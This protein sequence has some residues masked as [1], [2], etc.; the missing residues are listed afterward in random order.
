MSYLAKRCF[1]RQESVK[2]AL[3]MYTISAY[4]NKFRM[5]FRNTVVNKNK[6]GE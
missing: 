3:R 1:E 2:R 5:Y 6:M 4:K